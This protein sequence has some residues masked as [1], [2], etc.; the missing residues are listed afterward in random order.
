M[1]L[2]RRYRR[3]SASVRKRKRGDPL[4]SLIYPNVS[5]RDKVVNM[6]TDISNNLDWGEV[7]KLVVQIAS[8]FIVARLAVGWALERYQAEKLWDRRLSAYID[9]VFAVNEMR[10]INRQWFDDMAMNRDRSEQY[11]AEQSSRYASSRRMLE[12]AA[13][14][15][16]MLLPSTT[17]DIL[18]KLESRLSRQ[19]RFQHWSDALEDHWDALHEAHQALVHEG[20]EKLKIGAT[21]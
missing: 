15:S 2:L 19:G 20:R 17:L 4:A 3:A 5:K 14:T 11:E 12:E 16:E 13:A 18:G 9:L 6:L 21:K 8:A 1:H 10:R 7:L